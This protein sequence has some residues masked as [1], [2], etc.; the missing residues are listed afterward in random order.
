MLGD[1]DNLKPLK[2]YE[3]LLD[4][5][6]AAGFVSDTVRLRR[7]A[8]Y[9]YRDLQKASFYLGKRYP[10][11]VFTSHIMQAHLPKLNKGQAYY[12]VQKNG[13]DFGV[14]FGLEHWVVHDMDSLEIATLMQVWE[15]RIHPIPIYFI[16]EPDHLYV[17]YTRSVTFAPEVEKLLEPK[18]QSAK[19]KTPL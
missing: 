15:Q 8:S 2:R 3:S 19:R 16:Q 5:I 11:A 9:A 6:D 13:D 4:S 14:D 1:N 12:F 7:V 18:W 17:L 10:C